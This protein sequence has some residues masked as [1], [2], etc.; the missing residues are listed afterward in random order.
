MTLPFTQSDFFSVFARYNETVWPAQGIL[1]VLAA[2]AIL[3]ATR[4]TAQASRGVNAILGVMWIWMG[5]MYHAA[6]F[7]DINPVAPIMAAFFV[8]QGLI[9]T[10]LGVRRIPV[11]FAP[12]TGPGAWTGT[13]LVAFGLVAYPILSV[14]AGHSYPA[15]PTFG[16]PCPTT[17]FTLGVMIWGTQSLPRYALVIPLIWTVVGTSAALQLGVMED[18]GLAVALIGS[19]AVMAQATAKG[20]RVRLTA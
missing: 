6:F 8:L 15:Q 5:V 20:H 18:L 2:I 16:L 1:Y 11:V 9:F 19:L 4:G 13:F 14:A 17:I 3:L 10:A 12:A 7:S